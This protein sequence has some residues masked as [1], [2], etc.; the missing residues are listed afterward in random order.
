M[1]LTFSVLAR[2]RLPALVVAMLISAVRP[3]RSSF[4]NSAFSSRTLRQSTQAL[5]A[6][7]A[8]QFELS[9]YVKS[10]FL[11]TSDDN[12]STTRI[13]TVN[14]TFISP[15]TALEEYSGDEWLWAMTWPCAYELF[16]RESWDASLLCFKKRP[17]HQTLL[18]QRAKATWFL[19][20]FPC[21]PW[22]TS[23]LLLK[24]FLSGQRYVFLSFRIKQHSLLWAHKWRFSQ[25]CLRRDRHRI[26]SYLSFWW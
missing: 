6:S 16:C 13:K 14:P 2:S 17:L 24:A 7:R 8:G 12:I 9:D 20:T 3:F 1:P 22:R 5:S 25:T 4:S 19:W 10:N 18:L 23:I 15:S 21:G 26:S 11:Q